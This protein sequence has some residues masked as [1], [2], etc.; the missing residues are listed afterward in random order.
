MFT[1][2]RGRYKIKVPCLL[3]SWCFIAT[4]NE[5][6]PLF[7]TQRR[8]GLICISFKIGY[9]NSGHGIKF[10]YLP[11]NLTSDRVCET[12][13]AVGWNHNRLTELVLFT[14]RSFSTIKIYYESSEFQWFRTSDWTVVLNSVNFDIPCGKEGFDQLLRAGLNV[15]WNANMFSLSFVL[16]W[17]H[18]YSK[19]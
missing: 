15:I 2:G 12:V 3:L 10:I 9:K 18:R 16:T 4:A 1:F 7:I 13:Q 11:F 6:K 14:L 8:K 17:H 19:M 5:A